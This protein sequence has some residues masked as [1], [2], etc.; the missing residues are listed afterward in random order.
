MKLRKLVLLCSSIL[1]LG[2]CTTKGNTSENTSKASEQESQTPSSTILMTGI[3]EGT[4][5]IDINFATLPADFAIK[6]GDQT[7][8]STTK[9]AV[10]KDTTFTVEGA[11]NNINIYQATETNSIKQA[12]VSEGIDEEIA[13]ARAKKYLDSLAKLSEG[14]RIY[15]C[16]TDQLNGWSKT[17]PGVNEIITSYKPPL[18]F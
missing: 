1:L 2:A 3:N 12:G 14:T 7:I 5:C 13:C 4:I 10:T 6:M 9:V 17:E 16:I 18:A 15:F 8:T 11:L